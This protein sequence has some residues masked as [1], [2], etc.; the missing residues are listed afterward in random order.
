M[1][2]PDIIPINQIGEMLDIP[3]I[4]QWFLFF[5][6]LII[7]YIS[8]KYFKNTYKKVGSKLNSIDELFLISAF[9]LLYLFKFFYLTVFFFMLPTA[10]L[11]N[12][13]IISKIGGFIFILPFFLLGLIVTFFEI[14]IMTHPNTRLYKKNAKKRINHLLY[15]SILLVSVYSFYI[16]LIWDK[17]PVQYGYLFIILIASMFFTN[18][19]LVYRIIKWYEKIT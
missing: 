3:E 8:L 14:K 6:I 4:F 13:E 19:P 10:L 11:Q 17:I 5:I 9:G 2:L 15:I 12:A 16:I 7:G 18:N 1:D